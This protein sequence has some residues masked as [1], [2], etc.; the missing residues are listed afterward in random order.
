MGY[1]RHIIRFN[2]LSTMSPKLMRKGKDTLNMLTNG[3]I[4]DI[5]SV[6]KHYTDLHTV[7]GR[8]TEKDGIVD[9]R[10]FLN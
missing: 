10:I 3:A 4:L 1:R 2:L 8:S 9:E 7:H 6:F 5:F